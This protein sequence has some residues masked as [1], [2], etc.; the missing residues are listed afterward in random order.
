M[1][2]LKAP[3]ISFTGPL[4]FIQYEGQQSPMISAG[5]WSVG[6]SR[7]WSVDIC[8]STCLPAMIITGWLRYNETINQLFRLCFDIILGGQDENV[9]LEEDEEIL[10]IWAFIPRIDSK[11][12]DNRSTRKRKKDEIQDISSMRKVTRRGQSNIFR[13]CELLTVSRHEITHA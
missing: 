5:L 1:F 11:H 10:S 4:W 8:W 7:C 12:E 3:Q 2:G 13:L 6:W 9:H